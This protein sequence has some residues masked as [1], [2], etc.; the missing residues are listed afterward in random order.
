MANSYSAL[1]ALYIKSISTQLQDSLQSIAFQTLKPAQVVIVLDGPINQPCLNVLKFFS[2]ILPLSIIKIDSNVGLGTALNIGLEK[3]Q[4]KYI[5]R[6]DTDDINHQARAS[7]L[8]RHMEK[9]DLDVVGS[10]VYEFKQEGDSLKKIISER[11]VPLSHVEILRMLPWRNP[12]NHPSVLLKTEVLRCVGGYPELRY[13]QDYCLWARIAAKGFRFGNLSE[14]LVYMRVA[15][16]MTRRKNATRSPSGAL[17]NS[18]LQIEGINKFKIYIALLARYIS[19]CL[20]ESL[21]TFIY[22]FCL[23]QRCR[24]ILDD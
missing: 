4:S 20:P 3:I 1:G 12:I 24:F 13:Q 22:L 2:D 15:D 8:M 7:K 9:L 10:A 21:L 23:R 14:S 19:A 17:V 5:L 18:L 6:F 11:R 16:Q